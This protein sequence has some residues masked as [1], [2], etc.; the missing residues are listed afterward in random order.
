MSDNIG[1]LIVDKADLQNEDQAR[2][3]DVD[4]LRGYAIISVIALHWLIRPAKSVISDI[5]PNLYSVL[6]QT[7][8][9]VDI[10][11]V[12][13]GFLIGGIIIKYHESP[14][15]ISTFYIQ[16]SLRIIP[17]YF[18]VI[19][20]VYFLR[21]TILPDSSPPLWS[22]ITFSNNIFNSLNYEP[23]AEFGPF[24][25]LA[26]EEQFYIIGALSAFQFGRKGIFAV[27]SIF[28]LG[29]VA[30]RIYAY[31]NPIGISWWPL[32]LGHS[33]PIGRL[34]ERVFLRHR[35]DDYRLGSGHCVICERLDA[36][37]NGYF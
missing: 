12:V 24:W 14:N 28:T 37:K 35:G 23:I 6:N 31:H 13:S 18:I 30:V 3:L 1:S 26:I 11:F 16:R 21:G 32:T 29:S 19:F 22:Y 4:C 15:F 2:R 8:Q 34:E 5:N 36:S 25:S 27:A 20:F 17:L 7:A 10:F 9:G 33:D